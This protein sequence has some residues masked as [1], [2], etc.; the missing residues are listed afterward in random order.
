MNY[1]RF[2]RRGILAAAL[3]A[4][5]FMPRSASA[6]AVGFEGTGG[7]GVSGAVFDFSCG[8][9]LTTWT[10]PFSVLLPD[11]LA[12]TGLF[13][14]TFL[15]VGGASTYA[16]LSVTNVTATN[17]GALPVTDNIYFFS[18]L[19]S[20]S[21]PGSAGVGIAGYYGAAGLV[22]PTGGFYSASSQAQMNYLFAPYNLGV[23]PVGFS[24]TTPS[25]F[26]ICAPCV[27]N[28]RFF[29]LARAPIVPGGVVQLVGGINFTL[30]AGSQI[31]L[32][33]SLI[34]DANYPELFASEVPE[35]ASF[36]LLGAGLL[37][38]GLSRSRRR[39]T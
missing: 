31:Y 14:E 15:Q 16:W 37:G 9:C 39:K 8:T 17:L 21:V 6:A 12:V 5:L 10:S 27:S 18:D 23:A 20:P 22:F 32:P 24:L 28:T 38:L 2:F 36:A 34:L 1:H 33:G 3:A 29:E 30:A 19:F 11:G 4:A 26:V 7:W 13:N 35:P 25:T